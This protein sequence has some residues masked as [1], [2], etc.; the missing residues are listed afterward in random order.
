MFDKLGWDGHARAIASPSVMANADSALA[1]IIDEYS[2]PASVESFP[3]QSVP[4]AACMVWVC[5][6]WLS[7]CSREVRTDRD[8]RTN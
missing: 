5:M 7:G 8:G 2:R 1:R 4:G 3:S 6:A